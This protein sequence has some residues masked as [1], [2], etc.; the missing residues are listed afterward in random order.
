MARIS[1]IRR[2]DSYRVKLKGRFAAADLGRL[3]RAC[4][5]ALEHKLAP[6]QLNLEQVTSIDKVARGYLDRLRVRGARIQGDGA[7]RQVG[8]Q[9]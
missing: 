6:L 8:G 4:G 7:M 2:G 1:V 3:E 9:A 5:E